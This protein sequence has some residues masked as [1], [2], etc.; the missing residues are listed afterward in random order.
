MK[1]KGIQYLTEVLSAT[2]LSW[3]S[4]AYPLHSFGLLSDRVSF[5]IVRPK[6]RQI[7]RAIIHSSSVRVMPGLTCGPC[8]IS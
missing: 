1:V 3:A 7:M 8:Q 2:C 6:M 4:P 5:S